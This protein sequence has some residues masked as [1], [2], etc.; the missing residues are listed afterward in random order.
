[1]K[2]I[3]VDPSLNATGAVLL[4]GAKIQ[5]P[6][7]IKVKAKTKHGDA[8]QLEHRFEAIIHEM[9]WYFSVGD[10]LCIE[11]N[12][13]NKKFVNIS[14]LHQAQLIGAIIHHAV[15]KGLEV[16]RVKPKQGKKSLAGIGNADKTAMV[17]ASR[18]YVTQTGVDYKDKAIAD[19]IGIALAGRTIHE[20]SKLTTK[21]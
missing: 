18:A 16:V 13:L 21:K 19:A 7:C 20:A 14:T 5:Q 2:Y 12:V 15:T 11:E 8:I 17:T 6:K 9:K 10:V 3:G 4:N 1:M